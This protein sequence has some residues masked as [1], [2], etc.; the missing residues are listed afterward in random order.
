MK[1]ILPALIKDPRPYMT[2][3]SGSD[4]TLAD[5]ILAVYAVNMCY[6]NTTGFVI[7]VPVTF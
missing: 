1:Q 4:L 2:L 6:E 7:I 3:S 5:V